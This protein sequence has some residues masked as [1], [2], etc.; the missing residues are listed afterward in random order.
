MMIKVTSRPTEWTLLTSDDSQMPAVAQ[1]A[2]HWHFTAMVG[3]YT[4]LFLL[5]EVLHRQ[6][7]KKKR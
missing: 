2:N 7:L 3:N 4:K 5:L 1:Q 6:R